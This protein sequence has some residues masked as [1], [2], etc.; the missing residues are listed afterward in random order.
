MTIYII[1]RDNPKTRPE[2]EV[3]LNGSEAV[4][5]VRTEYEETITGDLELNLEEAEE[6]NEDYGCYWQI[7]EESCE[8]TVLID[9]DWD[10]DR[11]EWRIT[12]HEI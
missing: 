5:K 3:L 10:G 9:A 8:G 7:D 11:W 1:E 12:K 2:P 6:G 4:T